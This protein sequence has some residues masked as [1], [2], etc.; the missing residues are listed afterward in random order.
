MTEKLLRREQIVIIEDRFEVIAMF[1][2]IFVTL[3]LF[4]N[5]AFARPILTAGECT[6]VPEREGLIN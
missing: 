4:T 3:F 1:V 6:E 5:L 2:G